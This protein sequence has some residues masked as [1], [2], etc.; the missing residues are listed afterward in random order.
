[1]LPTGIRG[2]SLS[3]QPSLDG[4]RGLSIIAVVFFHLGYFKSGYVGVQIF[5]VLSGF[6]ISQILIRKEIN[7]KNLLHFILR[8]FARLVPVLWLSVLVGSIII[9][10]QYGMLQL[11][12]PLRAAL[13]L[14]NFFPTDGGWHDIWTPTWSLAAEEQFYII[15]PLT[16][17]LANKFIKEYLV[18]FI[19]LFYYIFI[20]FISSQIFGFDLPS[21]LIFSPSAIALG[22]FLGLGHFKET[23]SLKFIVLILFCLLGISVYTA[24]FGT[25]VEV[26]TALLIS[27][28]QR[29]ESIVHKFLNF[30]PIVWVGLLSYSIY[31]WHGILIPVV[32]SFFGDSPWI[33]LTV[34]SSALL[35]LSTT[36]FYIFE[37]PSRNWIIKKFNKLVENIV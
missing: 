16:L 36:S 20:K 10:I 15:F 33:F 23:I 9:Y 31:I 3:Y 35:L 11:Q 6:L 8:R 19:Y 13:Y 5:F 32:F 4:I 17:L 29:N 22:C 25:T 12:Y 37:I 26:V 18:P 28:L 7:I 1:M 21:H 27:Y 14:R 24:N 34:F 30:R 2:E